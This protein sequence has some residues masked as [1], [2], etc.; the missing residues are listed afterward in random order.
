MRRLL[1]AVLLVVA[2]AQAQAGSDLI[3]SA[4]FEPISPDT[5]A[6]AGAFLWRATFGPTASDINDLETNGYEAWVDR[7]MSLPPTLHLPQLQAF[8]ESQGQGERQRVWWNT[9]QN[10]PDQF[11]QR[12]AFALSQILVVSDLNGDLEGQPQ[13]LAAYYDLLVTNAFGNYR[14]LL[15]AVTLTPVM[16]HYLSMFRSTRFAADSIEPDENYARE[17]MQL[18]S[19]GLEE[20]NIDGSVR[21]Q[22]GNPIPTYDQDDI[23]GLAEAFT[24]WNFAGA[25]QNDGNCEWWE[26]RWPEQNW[27]E[28]MEP[29]QVT[30]PNPGEQPD[31][32]HV[33]TAKTIVGGVVL[34]AGQSAEQDMQQALNTLFNHPNVGPF[35]AFR[36]IQRLVTSNPSPQ[37]IARVAGVFNDNGSGVR[38]DLGAVFRAVLLDPDALAGTAGNAT[39]GKL[40]EPMFFQTQLN[41]VYNAQ[42]S[43]EFANNP[44]CCW[45]G[46]IY[47]PE[48][49]FGQAALRSPS[50]FNFFKPNFAQPGPIEAQGLVSPEFEISTET[51]VVGIANFF[52]DTLT[53]G[54]PVPWQTQHELQIG[55][56]T[57]L[58]GN[59][60]ALVDR[61]NQDLLYGALNPTARQIIIDRISD[62]RPDNPDQRV[63][64]ALYYIITSPQSVVQQ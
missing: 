22:G 45:P 24:G 6:E 50:V 1:C 28:P 9:A 10:A 42:I 7:Q 54:A 40:R 15:E 31:D 4:G 51:Q 29:C 34:P 33:R 64:E 13:A 35:L 27:L 49:F 36:L 46:A 59:P 44:D 17:I 55:S 14:D 32:Y 19:I 23:V 18:F 38:G 39:F 53:W 57:A 60:T 62:I 8:G 43:P 11:R 30:D 47:A 37:Y 20:L 12:A 63:A 21:T 25:D 41:R 16:G 56:L 5:N 26:W 3:F 48:R 2:G 58:A 61:V 52:F